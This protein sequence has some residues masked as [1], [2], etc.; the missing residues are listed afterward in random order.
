MLAQHTWRRTMFAPPDIVPGPS[1]LSRVRTRVSQW[2]NHLDLALDLKD[3]D[4]A[5]ARRVL[6]ARGVIQ[7][8]FW[9]LPAAARVSVL[10]LS[11]L[12]RVIGLSPERIRQQRPTVM[13]DLERVC[14]SCGDRVRC[15]RDLEQGHSRTTYRTFCPNA[16]TLD[17]LRRE[18]GAT[19]GA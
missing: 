16:D 4:P 12:M 6:E 17:A 7:G 1:L 2:R 15:E 14:A 19:Q 8:E 11:H 18:N 5:Q 3:L 9:Q 13:Q 10:L